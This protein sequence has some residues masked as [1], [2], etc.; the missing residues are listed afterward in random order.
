MQCRR[1]AHKVSRIRRPRRQATSAFACFP[2]ELVRMTLPREW[3]AIACGNL[4][5]HQRGRPLIRAAPYRPGE[6]VGAQEGGEKYRLRPRLSRGTLLSLARKDTALR[7]ESS[8]GMLV[9][10]SLPLATPVARSEFP[11]ATFAQGAG[12]C[13]G[14]REASVW[15]ASVAQPPR[16]PRGRTKFGESVPPAKMVQG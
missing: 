11:F 10:A 9:A 7:K 16:S 3:K 15:G 4:L 8:C 2:P 12:P 5:T 6:R 14:A 13:L 1:H